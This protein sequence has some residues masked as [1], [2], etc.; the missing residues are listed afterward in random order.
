M[1][2]ISVVLLALC[3]LLAGVTSCSDSDSDSGGG[4]SAV[5]LQ[6]R[7]DSAKSGD[8]VDVAGE[9]LSVSEAGSYTLKT[10]VTLK[11]GDLMNGSITVLAAG[12]KISEL[13]NVKSVVVDAA[14][15]DGDFTIEDCGTIETVTVYGGGSNSIH[16]SGTIVNKISAVKEKVR[17]LLEAASK[18]QKL[19][20]QKSC[21]L[22]ASDTES[23]FEAVTVSEN[24]ESVVLAE[25]ASVGT[26]ITESADSE[27]KVASSTVKIAKAG[28]ASGTV[29]ITA[30][31]GATV[32]TYEVATAE[33]VNAAAK[34]LKADDAAT[35]TLFY[36]VHFGDNGI[37]VSAEEGLEYHLDGRVT[38]F[39]GISVTRG[40]EGDTVVLNA[41][42]EDCSDYWDYWIESV[43]AASFEKGKNYTV[44]VELKAGTPSIVLVQAQTGMCDSGPNKYFAVG[45]EWKTYTFNTG[46]SID[47]FDS[48]L[49]NIPIGNI[50]E[51]HIRN[52]TVKE[53]DEESA[54]A[55]VHLSDLT[56]SSSPDEVTYALVEGGVKFTFTNPKN[57]AHAYPFVAEVGTILKIT[58]PV[59]VSKA[60]TVD[61][62]LH[63]LGDKYDVAGGRYSF[64]AGKTKTITGYLPVY[65]YDEA[66]TKRLIELAIS[67]EIACD[68]TVGKATAEK[69]TV[70]TF[71]KEDSPVIPYVV[72]ESTDWQ[73]WRMAETSFIIK[74]NETKSFFVNI[75]KTNTNLET[76]TE[77]E[78]FYNS[79]WDEFTS[80]GVLG[81]VTGSGINASFGQTS[82]GDNRYLTIKSTGADVKKVTVGLDEEC[83]VTVNA[84]TPDTFTLKGWYVCGLFNG[85][86]AE[87]IVAVSDI[88]YTYTFT[89]V[90]DNQWNSNNQ[91]GLIIDN[92]W[93]RKFTGAVLE[94]GGE[95]QTL[96]EGGGDDNK[97]TGCEPGKEYI[98]TFT[99]EDPFLNI[100]TAKVEA[101][102]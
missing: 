71:F 102:E 63:S 34:E 61:L 23:S 93:S 64:E 99:V 35:E 79:I 17:I 2:K 88:V 82:S 4:S 67:P 41:N 24:A 65:G 72:G 43:D 76:D 22:Q 90:A 6:A 28:S 89:A 46:N 83:K 75:S 81:E 52:V 29:N 60:T 33:E 27:I 49:M 13:K 80:V 97:I 59:T 48:I 94:V 15:G 31:S 86:Q 54:F 39:Q 92:A 45:T 42:Y 98:I 91:F 21:T 57:W 58:A 68:V 95:A 20:A 101:V 26:L 78:A 37:E 40:T 36:A 25:N 53:T 70:D 16:I 30:E 74:P 56:T 85:W 69:I 73:W 19:F 51:L 96:V 32:P 14:V 50:E 18:I 66:Q 9:G 1:R 87:E 55:S 7:L 100:V 5:T 12:V 11:N 47:D 8:T 38:I 77:W 84:G 44:S 10:A 62:W 3:V